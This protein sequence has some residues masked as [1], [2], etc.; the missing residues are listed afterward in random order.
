MEISSIPLFH[1]DEDKTPRQRPHPRFRGMAFHLAGAQDID[2][3]SEKQLIARAQDTSRP[4]AAEMALQTLV[5]SHMGMLKNIAS[6]VARKNKLPDAEDDLLSEAISSFIK[7][8]RRYRGETHSTRLAT[9]AAYVVSG[10]VVN[11]VLRNKY[12]FPVGT[13]SQDR[14]MIFGYKDFVETFERSARI[15][16]DRG[17]P[18]HIRKLAEIAEVGERSAKRV[19]DQQACGPLIDIYTI[20]IED[21]QETA[22]PAAALEAK[23]AAKAI[24]DTLSEVREKLNQRDQSILDT[25]LEHDAENSHMRV[26]LAQQ[27]GITSERVGQIYRTAITEVR[28]RLKRKGLTRETL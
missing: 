27:F 23:T 12:A 10:D 2:L 24:L 25:L 1:D 11:F 19:A 5:A 4:H 8:I 22:D 14:V 18:K 9:F 17:N 20:D 28:D 21:P 3:P 6:K 16:F 15:D 13:S 26:H 7:T